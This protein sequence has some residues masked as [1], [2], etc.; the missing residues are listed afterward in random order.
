MVS[1][2]HVAVAA[3][4]TLIRRWLAFGEAGFNGDFDQFIAR[5]Y[6]RCLSGKREM[7]FD[8]LVGS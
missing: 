3:N 6:A 8:Q 4:K 2:P 5:D 1:D 7:D